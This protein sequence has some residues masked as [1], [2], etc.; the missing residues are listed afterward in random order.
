MDKLADLPFSVNALDIGIAF[1]LLLSAALA[2]M[3]GFV[4]EVLSVAGWVGAGFASI[5]G[6]PY[7]KPYTRKIIGIEIVADFS[8]GIVIFVV[9]LVILSV[10]TRAISSRVKG[11]ALN[12]IDRSLGFLFGLF[13]GALV[14][15]IA[16]ILMGMVYPQGD[17]L[18]I[19]V[20]SRAMELV[21]PAALMLTALIPDNFTAP[22]AAKD[23]KGRTP[24][25]KDATL[26]GK[27]KVIMDMIQPKPKGPDGKDGDNV[28]GYGKKERQ[29]M[30]RLNDSIKDQP[31]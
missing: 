15:V 26:P 7:L 24:A 31:R 18:Y 20:Q 30:E 13:R 27:R 16:Y 1:I 19:V 28:V 11:S 12:A 29:Q 14:V 2:Y 5:Y 9:A 17:K 21:R 4:H 10:L 25:E 3:R 22:K 23:P 8:A 6:F